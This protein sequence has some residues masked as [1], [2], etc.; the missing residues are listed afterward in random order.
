MR[1]QHHQRNELIGQT[2]AVSQNCP[3]H[4]QTTGKP[5]I[6]RG[7]RLAGGLAILVICA[8]FKAPQPEP[9]RTVA[10]SETLAARTLEPVAFKADI[11]DDIIEIIE[12]LINPDKDKDDPQTNP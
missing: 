4:A 12:T 10:G 8:I 1:T 3:N 9:I 6:A 7:L 5:G 11:I 2:E